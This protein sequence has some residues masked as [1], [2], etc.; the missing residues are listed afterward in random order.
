MRTP[1]FVFVTHKTKQYIAE[2]RD[3]GQRSTEPNTS[4]THCACE[5]VL[6]EASSIISGISIIV[7]ICKTELKKYIPSCPVCQCLEE[8]ESKLT[9]GGGRNSHNLTQS[10]ATLTTLTISAGKTLTICVYHMS[11]K[12]LQQCILVDLGEVAT[13]TI[14]AGKM[15]YI[16]L[17]SQFCICRFHDK[18]QSCKYEK[19]SSERWNI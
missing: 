14:S 17:F 15:E 9:T 4:G 5:A 12:Y 18:Y 11:Y 6:G 7:Q 2:A 10:L 13:L 8:R 1:K 16:D 19:H 3:R